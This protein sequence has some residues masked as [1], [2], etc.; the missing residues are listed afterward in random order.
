M[1]T[2]RPA[3]TNKTVTFDHASHAPQLRDLQLLTVEYYTPIR[4]F[5]VA[6]C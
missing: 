6:F 4:I 1:G 2:G 5:Q 3:N